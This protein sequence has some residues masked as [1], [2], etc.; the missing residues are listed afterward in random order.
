VGHLWVK[1]RFIVQKPTADRLFIPAYLDD[2]PYLDQ[3]QYIKSL[4]N[5][6]EVTRLQRQYG[7]WDVSHQGA[8]F[9]R[10]WFRKWEDIA[11]VP[12]KAQTIRFWD[13]AATEDGGD[14]TVGTKLGWDQENGTWFVMDVRRDQLGPADVRRLVKQTAEIDGRQCKIR[15]EQEPGASG[16]SLVDDYVRFLAGYDVAGEKASGKKITRWKPFAAQAGAGHVVVCNGEWNQIWLDE[17]CAVPD[18]EHDDQADS[19]AGAFNV[20]AR[21]PRGYYGVSFLGKKR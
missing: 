12:S 21:E 2:N 10:D 3:E 4:E 18:S 15:I 1:Q 5:L 17:M 14:Y 16:K 9:K 11:N 8:M 6:D 13:L 7:D 20:L 19:V